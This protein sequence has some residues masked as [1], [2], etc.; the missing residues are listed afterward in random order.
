MEDKKGFYYF[1]EFDDLIG[2]FKNW[3][4]AETAFE[5]S[6]RWQAKDHQPVIRKMKDDMGI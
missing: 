4:Q 2:P 3:Q 5:A 6:L 1:D